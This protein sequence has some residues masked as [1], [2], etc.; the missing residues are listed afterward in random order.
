MLRWGFYVIVSIV[1]AKEHAL[2]ILWN[3]YSLRL[4]CKTAAL[5]DNG[6][7]KLFRLLARFR[8]CV[9]CL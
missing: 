5:A 3:D 1:E 6:Q 7:V 9:L 4:T 8:L 2:Y